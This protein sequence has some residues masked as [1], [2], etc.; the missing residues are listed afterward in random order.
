[1]IFAYTLTFLAE[2]ALDMCQYATSG[3]FPHS[4]PDDNKCKISGWLAHE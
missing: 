4:T 2:T 3:H 1:M